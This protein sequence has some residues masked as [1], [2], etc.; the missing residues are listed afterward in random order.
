MRSLAL[1]PH[2]NLLPILDVFEQHGTAYAVTPLLKGLTLAE[3][4]S[5]TGPL[6]SP[7]V[8]RVATGLA[9]AL[10]ALHAEGYLHRDL[11]PSNVFLCDDGRV[12]LIDMDTVH[13]KDTAGFALPR[14]VSSGY[15]PIE[16]YAGNAQFSPAVGHLRPGRHAVPRPAGSD[17]AV[18]DGPDHRHG[19]SGPPSAVS[20]NRHCP[21]PFRAPWPCARSTGH[22]IFRPSS[23]CSRSCA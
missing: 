5:R 19:Q 13:S 14:L 10:R 9:G 3:R 15:T 23:N 18:S 7:E 12:L 16:Q 2:P 17:A 8:R 22:K 1:L 20:S 21:T 6:L 4:L 11:K